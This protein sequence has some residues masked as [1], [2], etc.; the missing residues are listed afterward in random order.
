MNILLIQILRLGDALQLTP[1][2]TGIKEFFPESQLSVLT[3]SLG[4][5]IFSVHPHVDHVFELRKEK[6]LELSKSSKQEDLLS[7]VDILEAELKPVLAKEWDWVVNFSYSFPSALLCHMSDG[8]SCSGFFA[9]ENRQYFSR[10]KWFAY[11]VSAFMNRKYSVFNWVDVNKNIIG[12]PYVPDRLHFTLKDE[13]LEDARSQLDRL[14]LNGQ[15]L[16]GMHPGASGD[17]KQWPLENFA[18]LG[19]RLVQKDDCRI[20]VFGDRNEADLGRRLRD[21]IGPACEDMTGK[22]TLGQ[23]GALLS[24]CDLLVSNDTGPAHLASAVG[25]PVI[26]LFFSTHFVET[27]A[28]GPGHLAI[29]PDIDCFPCQGTASCPDKLCLNAIH[30]GFVERVILN[31][32]HTVKNDQAI[33]PV[34][35][36]GP[37]AVSVSAFDPWANLEWRPID[38]RALKWDDILRL[39]YK[40]F[41]LSALKDYAV[42][43]QDLPQYVRGLVSRFGR[44]EHTG[45]AEIQMH[46]LGENLVRVAQCYGEGCR[47][48]L[49]LYESLI[50]GDRDKVHQL[51]EDLQKK[52]DEI[53][54]LAENTHLNPF[55][56][57]VSIR[58]DNILE[59][60]LTNLSLMTASLYQEAQNLSL[61]LKGQLERIWNMAT[62]K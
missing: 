48:S 25:T 53:A 37:V 2:I 61:N 11:S 32:D 7:A 29:Y 45:Q 27:G 33:I 14:G 21:G 30:P 44:M 34:E 56:E 1:I 26:G 42:T 16:I 46:E 23:L 59:P 5:Q 60:D 20:L 57:Y 12:L 58:R 4:G 10:E 22:T 17:H 38:R 40:V 24:K 43:E 35:G 6:L 28:F 36:D 31:R 3:S 15:K 47:L 52:E 50:S 18:E 39:A 51:G 49:E 54:F 19:R 41:W 55:M 8:V 62:E 9:N 13:E